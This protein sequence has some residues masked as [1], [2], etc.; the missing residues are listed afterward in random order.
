[1]KAAIAIMAKAPEPGRAKTRLSPPLAAD[2]AAE[3]SRRFLLDTIERVR[4]VDGAVVAVF[5][6]PPDSRALFEALAPGVALVPQAGDDLGDR[7]VAGF[8]HLLARG[9]RPVLFIGSDTPTLPLAVFHEA[10]AR[11]AEP[12]VDVALGPTDDGGYYLIG[13]RQ[14][15]P[16]LF[17]SIPWS[18]ER[19]AAET[20][21]RART[22]GLRVAVLPRWFDV[23][24]A[25]DLDRLAQSMEDEAEWETSHT[26]R[27]LRGLKSGRQ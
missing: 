2:V 16:A 17:A 4:A 3:L 19:V 26:A 25:A 27:F 20:L 24:T 7:L 10:L 12:E 22:A 13:L 11:L 8:E 23:D 6:T 5:Y 15:H 14:H 21:R 1:M 18:S 9:H